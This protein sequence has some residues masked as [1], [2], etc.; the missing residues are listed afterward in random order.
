MPAIVARRAPRDLLACLFRASRTR[1]TPSS[2]A[3]FARPA[4]PARGLDRMSLARRGLF[5]QI[6]QGGSECAP[7]STWT[8]TAA[9]A[10]LLAKMQREIPSM[11][12]RRKSRTQNVT[13]EDGL[14][15]DLYDY[16]PR[17]P[18]A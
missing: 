5:R 16:A 11:A 6:R 13:T 17:R 8:E 9:S 4:L 3:L 14:P 15:A 1:S 2:L 12:R 7:I 18:V 10:I